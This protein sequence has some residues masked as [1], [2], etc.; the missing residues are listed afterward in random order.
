M[1]CAPRRAWNAVT[2]V[3][4][5][6]A[7]ESSST[8]PCPGTGGLQVY[9]PRRQ[10]PSLIGILTLATIVMLGLGLPAGAN[11]K[12][13]LYIPGA[14]YSGSSDDPW[15]DESW[16]VLATSFQVWVVADCDQPINP[17]SLTLAVPTIDDGTP[18]GSPG[19]GSVALSWTGDIPNA[20]LD[21]TDEQTGSP[22]YF[23]PDG[24][25]VPPDPVVFSQSDFVYG[26]P[27]YGPDDKELGTGVYPT[28]YLE[29]DLG[30]MDACPSALD[31]S[32]NEAGDPIERIWNTED[33]YPEDGDSPL[34]N[35]TGLIYRLD[36][37]I[38]GFYLV[39]FDA[40]NCTVVNKK[41]K[42]L[43][44][45]YSHNG[46]GQTP[47]PASIAFFGAVIVGVVARKV[48]QRRSRR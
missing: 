17:V 36:V 19:I 43:F 39:N 46:I 13:Q 21:R 4:N 44:A 38:S 15:F 48:R 30:E 2:R 11:P 10:A 47:E 27:T 7:G 45:P 20:Y 23:L 37:S 35:G 32:V 1:D 8:G 26:T 12:L 14:V 9:A 3:G 33:P 42:G 41:V 22:P 6:T 31:P 25:T 18:E 16:V 24:D 28:W 40:H 5:V 34:F 29:V